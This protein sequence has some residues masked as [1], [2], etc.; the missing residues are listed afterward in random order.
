M[1]N[2]QKE[3]TGSARSEVVQDLVARF[4]L[5]FADHATELVLG[6]LPGR[7]HPHKAQWFERHRISRAAAERTT[8]EEGDKR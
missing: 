6:K 3:L 1:P 7:H 8:E 2:T 4:D 5:G